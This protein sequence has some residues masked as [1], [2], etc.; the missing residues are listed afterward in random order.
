MELSDR[1]SR[2]LKS[3]NSTSSIEEQETK[4]YK[5]IIEKVGLVAHAYNLSTPGGWGKKL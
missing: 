5:E 1:A 4:S 2:I 3:V